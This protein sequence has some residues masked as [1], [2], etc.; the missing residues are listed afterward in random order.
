[1][2]DWVNSEAGWKKRETEERFT[3]GK[4]RL[5]GV[6]K[7]FYRR[8]VGSTAGSISPMYETPKMFEDCQIEFEL[9]KSKVIAHSRLNTRLT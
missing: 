8:M 3:F 1:M 9:Q 7:G 6:I 5:Y 2:K 4:Q